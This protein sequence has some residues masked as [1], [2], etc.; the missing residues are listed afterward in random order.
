[1]TPIEANKETSMRAIQAITSFKASSSYLFN[2]QSITSKPVK[3]PHTG[4][5]VN[6]V[7]V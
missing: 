2:R 7:G 6:Y 1:M 4:N 3:S 5:T